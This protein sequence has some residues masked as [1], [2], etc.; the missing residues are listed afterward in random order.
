[1]TA[2]RNRT[3]GAQELDVLEDW[4]V[5]QSEA[6]DGRWYWFTSFGDHG[7]SATEHGAKE[8]ST[9]LLRLSLDDDLPHTQDAL[10][11]LE[12]LDEETDADRRVFTRG[13]RRRNGT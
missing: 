1:V 9:Y 3:D 5:V 7:S 6:V 4:I 12:G 13:L 11:Y 10:N 8:L 2:W